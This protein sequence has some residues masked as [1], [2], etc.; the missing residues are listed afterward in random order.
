MK[1]IWKDIKNYED[2]YQVSSFGNVKSLKR[3][4]TLSPTKNRRGYIIV[5]LSADNTKRTFSVHRL[6]AQAF[7]DNPENKPQVNHIDGDKTNNCAYNLE[8]ATNSENQKHAFSNGLQTNIGN[9]NPKCRK[10]N[11]YDL[12]NNLIKT[13]HSIY[14]ITKQLGYS[15][16][17]IWRCCAGK[18]KTS[19]GYIWRYT[20]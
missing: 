7:I 5:S 12:S 4:I 6:V 13:W 9:N 1:E 17:S 16:S 14:E 3:D 19:H 15:R 8:W 18:Y 11:Q 10:I 2:L 20:D